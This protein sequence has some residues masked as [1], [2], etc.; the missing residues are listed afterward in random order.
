MT[1]GRG[2]FTMTFS[3]YEEMPSQLASKVIEEYRK[4]KEEGQK[5]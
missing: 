1:G 2:A 5:K 4:A 3:H